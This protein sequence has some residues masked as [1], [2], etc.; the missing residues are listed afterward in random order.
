MDLGTS[1]NLWFCSFSFPYS[2]GV[3]YFASFTT[4]LMFSQIFVPDSDIQYIAK[5]CVSLC[6]LNLKG[7]ISLTD[8][9]IANLIRRCT[10]LHSIVVCHT[11]FGMNSILALCTASSI[12]SNS[13]TAQFGK[14]HLDSLAANLQLLHMGGCKCKDHFLFNEL[15]IELQYHLSFT[16]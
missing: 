1:I 13:P 7:C 12:L 9:C 15:C 4:L 8:V 16:H 14:K 11:S 3:F 10:K 6:Y 5:F 2:Y